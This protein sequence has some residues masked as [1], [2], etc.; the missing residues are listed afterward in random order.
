VTLLCRRILLILSFV[1]V[2]AG[3]IYR[4]GDFLTIGACFISAMMIVIAIEH[5][6]SDAQIAIM[7][8]IDESSTKRES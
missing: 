7:K 2:F 5:G 3:Y 8:K 4:E 1:F 6:I